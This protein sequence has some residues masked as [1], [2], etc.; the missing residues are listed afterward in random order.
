MLWRVN[1]YVNFARFITTGM[2]KILAVLMA[3][4]MLVLFFTPCVDEDP[5][6]NYS[7][8]TEITRNNLP[9]HQDCQ[10]CCSPFCT[11]KCCGIP[12]TLMEVSVVF[13]DHKYPQVMDY[14]Y[15]TLFLSRYS[16]SIWEPP[17]A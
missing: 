2:K 1:I 17:K 5:G 15:P 7:P 11:C 16:S 9:A 14:F 6:M 12:F 13:T 8:G 3:F 4:Y 10:D